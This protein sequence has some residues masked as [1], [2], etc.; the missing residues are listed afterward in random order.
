[1]QVF[2]EQGCYWVTFSCS[3]QSFF[4]FFLQVYLLKSSVFERQETNQ[5]D[6]VKLTN[7]K[8]G[9]YLFLL[10]ITDTHGE[11]SKANVSVIVITPEMSISEYSEKM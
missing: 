1:M 7:L 3:F 4:L 8:E 5:T 6:T 10:T 11:T 2:S 9:S